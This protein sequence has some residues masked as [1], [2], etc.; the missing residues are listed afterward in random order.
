VAAAP[1]IVAGYEA[2]SYSESGCGC[3]PPDGDIAVGPNHVIGEVNN[4]FQVF[5]KTGITMTN[6]IKFDDFFG[7]CGAPDL[8]SSDPIAAYDPVADRFTIG[9]LRYDSTTN[10]SYVSLAVSRSPDPTTTWNQYCFEQ[11]F[12]GLPALYDFPHISVG[13][14]AIFT[15]G[16]LYPSSSQ[17]SSGARVNAYDKAAMYSGVITATQIYSDVVLNSDGTPADTLRPALFNVGL[18]SPTNYF[19]NVAPAP[20]TRVSLWR[21]TLPFSTNQFVA[22]GGVDGAPYLPPVPMIQPP[23]GQPMPPVPFIDARMLGAMW[24]NGTLY[25]THTI[26]CNDGTGSTDCVQWYQVGNINATPT[27]LQQGIV[28]GGVQQSRA[29]PNIAVDASGN[30]RLAYAYSSRTEPLGIK[31]VGRLASDPLNAMGTEGVVKLGGRA[32]I[33]DEGLRY[34]DYSGLVTDPDGV[35][36]W[37]LEEFAPAST[38]D[39]WDTWISAAQ[40]GPAGATATGTPPTATSTGTATAGATASA[41][42][43]G[44]SNGGPVGVQFWHNIILDP[45][46]ASGEPSNRI[47]SHNHAYVSSPFG[48]GNTSYLWRSQD[49]SRLTFQPRG[50]SLDHRIPVAPGGGDTDIAVDMFNRLHFFDLYLGNFAYTRSDDDGKTFTSQDPLPGLGSVADDRQ[51]TDAYGDEIY[52]VYRQVPSGLWANHGTIPVGGAPTVFE[53]GIPV[54]STV[55]AVSHAGNVVID[56]RL[57]C[58][59]LETGAGCAYVVY[60]DT[61]QL[62]LGR[63]TDHGK[64]WQPGIG[65]TPIIIANRAGKVDNIFPVIAI[66]NSGNLYVAWS[67]KSAS[68]YDIYY[69][70]STDRGNTWRTPVRVNTTDLKLNIFPYIAAG[71]DGRVDVVWYGTTSVN[72]PPDPQ[73]V[74]PATWH[75]YFAQTLN[76][77]DAVPAFTQTRFSQTPLHYNGICLS[78]TGCLADSSQDRQLL[79]F[80]EVNVSPVDGA[81]T[82]SYADNTNQT[83][84][85]FPPSYA[86]LMQAQQ[87]GGESAFMTSTLT[88]PVGCTGSATFP[89]ADYTTDPPSDASDPY[90][91]PTVMTATNFPLI[92]MLE[93]RITDETPDALTFNMIVNGNLANAPTA[94]RPPGPASAPPLDTYTWL[95][96]FEYKDYVYWVAMDWKSGAT[97]PR[98][99]YGNLDV[100]FEVQPPEPG[101]GL[102]FFSYNELGTLCAASYT[103]GTEPSLIRIQ[104]P[105]DKVTGNDNTHPSFGSQ[106]YNVT[107]YGFARHGTTNAT[108]TD[109]IMEIVDPMPP[110]IYAL[111]TPDP[112]FPSPTPVVGCQPVEVPTRTPTGSSTVTGTPTETGTPT[113]T[114]I[115]TET[116]TPLAATSTGT[117][118]VATSTDTALVVGT[119]TATLTSVPSTSTGTPLVATSTNTAL[120]ATSTGTSILPTGTVT[121]VVT[122]SG[123]STVIVGTG[124]PTRTATSVA[125]ASA[126]NTGTASATRT[127]V[128]ATATRTTAASTST[129]AAT[130]T[131]CTI[132]FADVPPTGEGSTFY[133]YVRCLAC[134]HIVGGYPCGEPGEDC[135]QDND[136]YYRP[137]ANVSRGQLSKIVANSAGLNDPIAEGQQQFADVEPGDPFY[138]YVERLAQTG[139]ISGY[140]CGESGPG[141][142]CD[143]LERPYFRPNNPATRGQISKIVSIAAGYDE[144]IPADQQTFTDVP[145]NSPFWVYIERLSD[146]GIISGYG[147]PEKCPT[148]T[149]CFRYTDNT[150]R[151]Q[152]AKIAA[153]AFF[154]NCQTP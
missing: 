154:P 89:C 116:G 82:I 110:Y 11:P 77:H 132:K 54:D 148:G 68:T 61:Q 62:R 2:I 121:I 100:R 22:A 53:P 65:G 7:T 117:P 133:S 143:S 83:G 144:D 137:G 87:V 76:G 30:V 145:T 43:T 105:F 50:V 9:I 130:A 147:D 152:M 149:P 127:S 38:S 63:T 84:V 135:N 95:T 10:T 37:H 71:S 79:D 103:T 115:P 59:G 151:G 3:L 55:A 32:L 106:L 40:F 58:G 74:T 112:N 125:I 5:T 122:P 44:T 57:D 17:Q 12:M 1:T 15:T 28:N 66:D 72:N 114:G 13:Q 90:D 36:I 73:T 126:T 108:L 31:H 98:F 101:T 47:D 14:D 25:A 27:L 34:G 142:P 21:W 93:S 60:N 86:Y 138:P 64:T 129:P 88:L 119:S 45:Q 94:P 16:N 48:V 75:G 97:Q 4:S 41:T 78:G 124:T 6:A 113:N 118:L 85:A 46:R 111:A 39:S 42:A 109:D 56:K 29:Y 24:Y 52:L 141:E 139:A 35:R 120:V 67:E 19:I 104:L 81:A 99:V 8:G 49:A 69:T 136:P 131:A 23:P 123:T 80:F 91:G 33:L 26:G 153:N 146:R 51:W 20:N 102:G 96:Q 92:D 128:A 107:S 18:P 150:S 140:P 70:S 134:R